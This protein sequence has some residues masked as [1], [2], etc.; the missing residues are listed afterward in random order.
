MIAASPAVGVTEPVGYFMEETPEEES[1]SVADIPLYGGIEWLVRSGGGVF[2]ETLAPPGSGIGWGTLLTRI[3]DTSG[4]CEAVERAGRT[5][6]VDVEV[7]LGDPGLALME[8]GIVSRAGVF[9]FLE[10]PLANDSR[11]EFYEY[12]FADSVDLEELWGVLQMMCF[13]EL[14]SAE[15]N[16]DVGDTE[17][18]V[19]EPSVIWYLPVGLGGYVVETGRGSDELMMIAPGVGSTGELEDVMDFLGEAQRPLLL[20]AL[21]SLS[22]A[23]AARKGGPGAPRLEEAGSDGLGPVFELSMSGFRRILDVHGRGAELGL[24]HA[25][26]VCRAE[27]EL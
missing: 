21:F 14:D 3:P 23:G 25:L 17:L 5:R 9:T 1:F 16:A 12:L 7:G 22:C 4:I 27:F 11:A 15:P 6:G 19:V 26:T 24:S 18:L 20:A 8:P 2:L 10:Y 13:V